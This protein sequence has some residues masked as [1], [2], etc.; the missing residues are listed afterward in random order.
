[1]KLIY[2]WI[3]SIGVTVSGYLL[4]PS[5]GDIRAPD[6]ASASKPLISMD[7]YPEIKGVK[8]GPKF[9]AL[10]RSIIAGDKV[11]YAPKSEYDGERIEIGGVAYFLCAEHVSGPNGHPYADKSGYYRII[12]QIRTH[13][14]GTLAKEGIVLDEDSANYSVKAL[15]SFIEKLE[16]LDSE[17]GRFAKK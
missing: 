4:L 2:F 12:M 11:P 8:Y 10:V 7:A 15:D 6:P 14:S 5:C 13:I 3:L 1:M 16:L 17:T 9:S